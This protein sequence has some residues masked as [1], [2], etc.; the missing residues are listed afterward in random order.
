MCLFLCMHTD[1]NILNSISHDII[2]AAFEV[3]K[4][5]GPL[6]CERV[7]ELSMMI[8]MEQRGHRI[9]HQVPL[10]MEY[11]GVV[12]PRA[13]VADMVVDDSIVLEFKAKPFMVMDE[14]RQIMTY[15]KLSHRRLGFL[16]N[17]GAKDFNFGK[18]TDNMQYLREG[19]YRII[20]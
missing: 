18:L 12:I 15:L 9:E 20:N 11:K 16:I 14:F 8:E 13:Y 17:F 7:Y 2:G 19:L 10:D 6:L 1:F 3:R 5:Y 4:T